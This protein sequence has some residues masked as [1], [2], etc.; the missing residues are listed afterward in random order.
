MGVVGGQ[1]S[2]LLAKDALGGI[3]QI[4]IQAGV[5]GKAGTVDGLRVVLLFQL[6]AHEIDPM[7][8]A[9][10]DI[11]QAERIG[12]HFVGGVGSVW[13]GDANGLVAVADRD[14]A[15][16]QTGLKHQH[17]HLLMPTQGDL[18]IGVDVVDRGRLRQAGQEGG[19]GQRQLVGGLAEVRLGGGFDAVGQV[20]VIILV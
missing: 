2:H 4:R 15:L 3:L 17:Q 19:L 1:G 13:R 16:L 11:R 10:L 6:R 9:H 20:A 14:A 5:D 12:L 18:A 8:V 7:R